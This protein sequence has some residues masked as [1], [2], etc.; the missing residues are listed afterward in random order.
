MSQMVA[1]HGTQL[2]DENPAIANPP[3]GYNAVKWQYKMKVAVA[4]SNVNKLKNI[5]FTTQFAIQFQNVVDFKQLFLKKSIENPRVGSSILPQ[6]T[7][8]KSLSV[9][10]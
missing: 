10:H 3:R 7:K 6:A 1:K 5:C 2:G 4:N 8:T 9:S